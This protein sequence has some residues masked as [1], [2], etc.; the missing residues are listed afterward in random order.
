MGAGDRGFA[1]R[2]SLPASGGGAGGRERPSGRRSGRGTPRE[3]G[4]TLAAL[5]VMMAVMAIFLTVAIESVSFQQRRERED[6]LI[7]RGSQY[8]EGIRLFR[9]RAGRFPVTVEELAKANP[10]VL[11]KVW[12]DPMTG[13]PN[14]AP[15]FLGEEGT[16]V[17]PT[18]NPS[19]TPQPTPPRAGKG[20]VG[21]VVGV[22]STVC[23]D[24]I[25]IYNGHTNYCE[26]KF[27]YDPSKPL[28]NTPVVAVPTP[29]P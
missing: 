28:G 26:W 6:E 10:R 27:F 4:F 12:V 13:K 24:S 1:S 18:P 5:V 3:S 22:R 19:A 23:Q 29:H 7:F 15:V 16:T 9:A 8:V 20:S 2:D 17:A 25:K 21:T 14:W 11:R